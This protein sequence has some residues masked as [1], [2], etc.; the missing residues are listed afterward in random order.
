MKAVYK[1]ECVCGR[2]GI[3]YGLFV[4]EKADVEKL[5]ASGDEVYFG[6]VLGK[7]SSVSCSLSWEDIQ[8]ITDDPDF[9]AKAQQ[10]HGEVGFNPV[11]MW[12]EQLKGRGG[13]E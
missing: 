3:L 1:L 10:L 7:H 4:A 11:E 6:E 2:M 12:K 8:M 13:E 9:T 5:V